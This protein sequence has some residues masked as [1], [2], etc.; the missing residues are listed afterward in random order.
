[1]LSNSLELPPYT[2]LYLHRS[3]NTSIFKVY[4]SWTLNICY[5]D[6][7]EALSLK[8]LRVL[9]PAFISSHTV[10]HLQLARYNLLK[11]AS[12]PYTSAQ[13]CKHFWLSLVNPCLPG[14]NLSRCP[15]FQDGS[16][17]ILSSL[18]PFQR[19]KAPQN[20]CPC[21]DLPTYDPNAMRIIEKYETG[22]KFGFGPWMPKTTSRPVPS[23]TSG[24][25]ICCVVM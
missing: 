2:F 7:G 23:A 18:P 21:C 10:S 6:L 15:R 12:A 25:V 24:Y 19:R 3:G 1:M 13:T 17:T 16:L 14:R 22:W 9:S 8:F 20:C 4:A 5:C 11:C